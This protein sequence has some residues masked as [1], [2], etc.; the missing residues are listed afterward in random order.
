LPPIHPTCLRSLIFLTRCIGWRNCICI[1]PDG[2]TFNLKM[3]RSGVLE[4][5]VS[6]ALASTGP[7]QRRPLLLQAHLRRQ[8]PRLRARRGAASGLDRSVRPSTSQF[9]L[10]TQN[11]SLYPTSNVGTALIWHHCFAFAVQD[12]SSGFHAPAVMVVRGLL[13]P[14]ALLRAQPHHIFLYR[15]R[16]LTI[17]P[18]SHQQRKRARNLLRSGR[19]HLVRLKRL[20]SNEG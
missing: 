4:L 14:F 6:A 15:P 13:W 5:K 2:R 10:P 17:I 8:A 11:V 12:I 1:G 3:C 20:T 7:E 16:S 18:P 19:P 9:C